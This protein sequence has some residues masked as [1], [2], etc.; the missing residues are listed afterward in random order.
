[1]RYKTFFLVIGILC[2]TIFCYGCNESLDISTSNTLASDMTE[3]A[4]EDYTESEAISTDYID[5][6]SKTENTC[7]YVYVCGQVNNP[8][9]YELHVGD[10]ICDAIKSAGDF[11]NEAFIEGLNQAMLVSDEMMVYVPSVDEK[12]QAN[13]VTVS[14]SGT[15]GELSSNSSGNNSS[16]KININ[17]ASKEELMMLPGV[18]ESRALAI[19]TYREEHGEFKA[20]EDIKNIQGIK[21]GI[22]ENIKDLIIVD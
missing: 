8:G 21:N 7:V 13:V 14:N 10:R 5:G 15:L 17:T 20:V 22:F 4:S 6:N 1:M 19:I 12:D 16:G 9:V 2:T 11:T 18:G 3:E